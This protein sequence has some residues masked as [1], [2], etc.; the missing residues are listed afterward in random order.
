MNPWT[1][2]GVAISENQMKFRMIKSHGSGRYICILGN[3]FRKETKGRNGL[4]SSPSGSQVPL[5]QGLRL[6][7]GGD[8]GFRQVDADDDDGGNDEK[9]QHLELQETLSQEVCEVQGIAAHEN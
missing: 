1:R 9:N 5:L 3:F 4:V 7:V 2:F 8:H 6:P